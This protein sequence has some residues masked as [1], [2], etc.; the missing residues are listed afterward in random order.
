MTR[1]A[2]QKLTAETKRQN[3]RK[4]LAERG[5]MENVAPAIAFLESLN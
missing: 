2:Q 4:T 5:C 1:L 3:R